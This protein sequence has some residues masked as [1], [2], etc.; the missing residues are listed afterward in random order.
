VHVGE[1]RDRIGRLVVTRYILQG[2]GLLSECFK[3][4]IGMA[5]NNELDRFVFAKSLLSFKLRS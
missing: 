4:L 3:A 2:N 5:F 1:Y